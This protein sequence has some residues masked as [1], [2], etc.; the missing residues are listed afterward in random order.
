MSEPEGRAF[1]EGLRRTS[2]SL[3]K[4]DCVFIAALNGAAFGGGME[5]VL[6]CDRRVAGGGTGGRVGAGRGEAG[7]HS[8]RWGT[9]RL[10]QFGGAG[11]GEGTAPHR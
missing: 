9:Q 2:M 7:N 6:S 8:R 5:L 1:L 3:E 11:A 4:S 10:A